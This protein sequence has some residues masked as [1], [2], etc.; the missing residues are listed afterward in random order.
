MD[1]PYEQASTAHSQAH[2][3][4]DHHQEDEESICKHA[5][6]DKL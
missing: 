3:H 4:L 2:N 5:H 6:Q 1:I